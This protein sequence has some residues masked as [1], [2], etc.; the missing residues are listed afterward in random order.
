M[1]SKKAPRTAEPKMSAVAA[2]NQLSPTIAT[3]HV[4]T[5]AMTPVWASPATMTN[6]PMTRDGS[7]IAGDLPRPRGRSARQ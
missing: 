2:P 7:E 6:S 4:P 3:V 5:V 1:L